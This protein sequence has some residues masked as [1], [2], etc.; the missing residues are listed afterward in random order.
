MLADRVDIYDIFQKLVVPVPEKAS[1][2][3]NAT[4]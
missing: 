2:P 4:T 3:P 1:Y